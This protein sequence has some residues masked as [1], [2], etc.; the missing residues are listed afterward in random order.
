[1]HP[2]NLMPSLI[3][4]AYT[5]NDPWNINVAF[6]TIYNF[7]VKISSRMQI[8]TCVSSKHYMVT[9]ASKILILWPQGMEFQLSS[10][11]KLTT[12]VPWL[13]R[14]FCLLMSIFF[15]AFTPSCNLPVAAFCI[16]SPVNM[17][18]AAA[19]NRAAITEAV[20]Q[21]EKGDMQTSNTERW[22][23]NDDCMVT[24][25]LSWPSIM[26]R[27]WCWTRGKYGYKRP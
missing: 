7:S 10:T 1:M 16:Y 11:W 24:N 22:S 2:V 12:E 27:D 20:G 8:H 26:C 25:P 9:I 13:M 18:V 6:N 14:I 19:S 4:R 5:R 21:I 17:A 3:G 23:H 15:S